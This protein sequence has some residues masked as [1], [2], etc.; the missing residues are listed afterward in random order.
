M[1]NLQTAAGD[2]FVEHAQMIMDP[3]Q[4]SPHTIRLVHGE[5]TGTGLLKGLRFSHCWLESGS[6]VFDYS[7]DRKIVAELERYYGIGKIIDI[8]GKLQRYSR[9]QALEMM[10]NHGHYGP[11]ELE[12]YCD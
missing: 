11:W 7:N 8:P 3:R 6:V 1:K 10:C 12:E 4:V 2:C 5:V 9:R